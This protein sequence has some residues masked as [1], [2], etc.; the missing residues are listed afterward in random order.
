MITFSSAIGTWVWMEQTSSWRPQHVEPGRDPDGRQGHQ[1]RCMNQKGKGE[2]EQPLPHGKRR[3]KNCLST[4][5]KTKVRKDTGRMFSHNAGRG[6]I[7][8]KKG[9]WQIASKAT[10]KPALVVSVKAGEIMGN[11]DTEGLSISLKVKGEGKQWLMPYGITGLILN[12][13]LNREM[14][15]GCWEHPLQFY[16]MKTVKLMGLP[17]MNQTPL[18]HVIWYS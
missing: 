6:N 15:G 7:K 4:E 3:N 13:L 14:G 5:W 2:R 8:G 12:L 10:E 11:S 18:E 16:I 17:Q 1:G 9:G